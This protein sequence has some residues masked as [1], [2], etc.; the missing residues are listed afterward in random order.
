MPK[1]AKP[2]HVCV[3]QTLALKRL[4]KRIALVLRIVA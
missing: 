3:T 4:G 2:R 1:P